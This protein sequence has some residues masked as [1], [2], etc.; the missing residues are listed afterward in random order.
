MQMRLKTASLKAI[1]STPLANCALPSESG[2]IL[3]SSFICLARTAVEQHP[4]RCQGLQ[5]SSPPVRPSAPAASCALPGPRS[6]PASPPTGRKPS[7][8]SYLKCA[9]AQIPSHASTVRNPL[10][11]KADTKAHTTLS[12]HALPALHSAQHLLLPPAWLCSGLVGRQPL[13]LWVGAAGSRG[14]PQ[15]FQRDVQHKMGRACTATPLTQSP[16]GGGPAASSSL[17]APVCD[18]LAS[19]QLRRVERDM[20]GR[21][22]SHHASCGGAAAFCLTRLATNQV[23]SR[24]PRGCRLCPRGAFQASSCS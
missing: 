15:G 16:S 19:V 17:K 12:G 7:S 9:D 18:R 23:V 6:G 24:T 10:G 11:L 21:D 2:S 13:L 1:K 5:A 8:S 14:C 3:Y 20:E 22:G 4:G